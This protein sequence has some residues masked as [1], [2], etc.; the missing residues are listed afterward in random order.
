MLKELKKTYLL[1]F[2]FPILS[3]G[4][5]LPQ[6]SQYMFNSSSINPAYVGSR[7]AM[8]ITFLNRNQWVG[9]NGAP[10]TQT[11]AIDSSVPGSHLGLG[12]SVIKDKLGYENTTYVYADASY[13]LILNDYYRFSFGL[14][15]GISKYGLDSDL[16]MDQSAASD[17]Y[18][19]KIFNQWKPNFGVGFYLRSD[20]LFIGLSSP[21]IISYTNETDVTYE[22][23][24]RASY[25]LA[26]GYLLK[27]NPQLKFKPTIMLKYTNGSPLSL[28]LTANFLI[29][30][31][32]WLGVAHRIN[33]AMGGYVS[34]QA[35]PALR[36]GYSYE[37]NTSNLRTYSS[38][39]HE[40]FVS[41]QFELPRPRCNCPNNF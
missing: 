22:A 21:R 40:I 32:L 8:V 25:Y 5:Q 3:I 23:I 18:L 2:L 11:L 4:Q 10:I 30:E 1:L 41:Y 15:A 17:E 19:D 35:S 34:I 7:E 39:S 36:F 27:F 37:F 24:E 28:D 14:K 20:E 6:F 38:G 29:N 16:L 12:L 33:D 31:T 9:V 13:M 26:G